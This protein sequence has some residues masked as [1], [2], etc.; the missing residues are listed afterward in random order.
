MRP[1]LPSFLCSLTAAVTPAVA[2]LLL[3]L[4]LLTATGTVAATAAA[5]AIASGNVSGL[6]LSP[7]IILGVRMI[8][9]SSILLTVVVDDK[10]QELVFQVK[11][12]NKNES[13][14]RGQTYQVII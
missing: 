5:I 2:L 12:I 6:R 3:S 11:Y 9:R 14:C 8:K 7:S 4:L 13:P 10:L 1:Q